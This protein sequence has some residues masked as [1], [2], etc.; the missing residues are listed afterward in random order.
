[1]RLVILTA[2]NELAVHKLAKNHIKKWKCVKTKKN[3]LE[4]ICEIWRYEKY[5]FNFI[6]EYTYFYLN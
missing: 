6:G 4:L 1:M 3:Y 5:R 2:L